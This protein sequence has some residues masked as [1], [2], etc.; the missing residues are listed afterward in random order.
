MQ[1]EQLNQ[2]YQTQQP[3]LPGVSFTFPLAAVS[4]HQI[5]ITLQI[6]QYGLAIKINRRN[7]PELSASLVLVSAF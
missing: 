4:H 6:K 2:Y 7:N 3:S 1:R 5:E